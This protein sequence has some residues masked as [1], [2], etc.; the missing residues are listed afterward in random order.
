MSHK[1]LCVSKLEEVDAF[2]SSNYDSVYCFRVY[3]LVDDS[4]L[5]GEEVDLFFLTIL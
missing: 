5:L 2:Y 4:F 1:R 3:G